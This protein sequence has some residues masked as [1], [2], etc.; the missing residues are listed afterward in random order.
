MYLLKNLPLTSSL[1]VLASR[2]VELKLNAIAIK[3]SALCVK[4]RMRIC[5]CARIHVLASGKGNPPLSD[6]HGRNTT[7]NV[8]QEMPQISIDS[9]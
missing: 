6:H 2:Q 1:S 4:R 8:R 9:P 5:I 3:R 7:T